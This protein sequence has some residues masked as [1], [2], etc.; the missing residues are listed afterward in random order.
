MKFR[1]RPVDVEAIQF[2]GEN[3]ADVHRWA[4][5]K[6]SDCGHNGTPVAEYLTLY[7]GDCVMTMAP[8]EWL[9]RDGWTALHTLNAEQFAR[10]YEPAD[11]PPSGKQPGKQP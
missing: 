3:A 11:R 9:V 1:K 10:M 2:T 6:S 7:L 8:G 4:N 5:A